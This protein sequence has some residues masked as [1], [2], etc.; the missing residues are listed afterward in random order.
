MG[1]NRITDKLRRQIYRKVDFRKKTL[2]LQNLVDSSIRITVEYIATTKKEKN[3]FLVNQEGKLMNFTE[4]SLFMKCY[5]SELFF[6]K[7]LSYEDYNEFHAAGEHLFHDYLNNEYDLEERIP[8]PDLFER[9]LKVYGLY[10]LQRTENTPAAFQFLSK[11]P[12]VMD[13]VNE[14][15]RQTPLLKQ[16]DAYVY[17]DRTRK[18]NRSRLISKVKQMFLTN[19]R[20]NKYSLN[21]KL[22]EDL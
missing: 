3:F 11:D 6:F 7:S 22:L 14:I 21:Y 15:A 8:N 9:V 17:Y 13:F 19:E 16:H 12:N 4:Q 18:V 1:E 10:R 5:K 2:A 20:S